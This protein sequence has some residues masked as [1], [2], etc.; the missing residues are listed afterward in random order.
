MLINVLKY[1]VFYYTIITVIINQFSISLF[2][3]I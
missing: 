2:F 1:I 3:S